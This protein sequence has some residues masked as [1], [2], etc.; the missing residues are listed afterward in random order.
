MS[1]PHREFRAAAWLLGVAGAMAAGVP[2]RAAESYASCDG[3]IDS[4]PAVV[5]SQGVWCLR[6]DLS[7]GQSS[8]TLITVSGNNITIDC[9]GFKLGGLAAGA[10]TATYG[11]HANFR[12]NT[13]VRRCNVRG[14]LVGIALPGGAGQVVEDNRLDGNTGI[15]IWVESDQGTIRRNLVVD[16]GGGTHWAT[17]R[18]TAI[19]ASGTT[20]V[21][22]NTVTGVTPS[23]VQDA[24]AT[25]ILLANGFA[26]GNRIS[27]VVSSLSS[28]AFLAQ[29]DAGSVIEGNHASGITATAVRCTATNV[30][31][32]GNT[33]VGVPNDRI[34]CIDGGGN[35][36]RP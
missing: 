27:G 5:S 17:E 16:T 30:I 9:N 1:R 34:G 33:F 8:G 23:A 12:Q 2:V 21:Q 11:I 36:H 25:G 32:R 15:G 35:V 19:Y 26:G 24:G 29:G 4:L 6:R 31:L 20:D 13:T 10:G 14:F 18:R 28:E 3:F 22:D 7:S